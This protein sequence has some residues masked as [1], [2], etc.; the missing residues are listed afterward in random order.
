MCVL[1][2]YSIFYVIFS[3]RLPPAAVYHRHT[4]SCKQSALP[5]STH[6]LIDNSLRPLWPAKK[7]APRYTK[8]VKQN[9]LKPLEASGRSEEA[10]SHTN[11]DG[12]LCE[13]RVKL[14]RMNLSSEFILYY[15]GPTLIYIASFHLR[16]CACGVPL[17]EQCGC[18]WTPCTV[19]LYL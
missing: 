3:C 16:S 1:L 17:L 15:A 8:N 14:P 10:L 13:T 12:E 6:P 5:T 19:S 18:G 7:P 11:N 2:A 4:P 9:H